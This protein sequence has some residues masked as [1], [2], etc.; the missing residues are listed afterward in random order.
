[1]K[2][3]YDNYYLLNSAAKTETSKDENGAPVEG[4]PVKV[5]GVTYDFSKNPYIKFDRRLQAMFDVRVPE[6]YRVDHADVRG[7]VYEIDSNNM[8][9][10]KYDQERKK[11]FGV[12][13]KTQGATPAP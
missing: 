10:F 12:P 2:Y 6:E 8:V 13:N 1:L 9:Y 3:P 4:Q 7:R 5:D 11:A